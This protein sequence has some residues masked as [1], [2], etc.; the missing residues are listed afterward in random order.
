MKIN[1]K[2]LLS[3][4]I[5][6]EL[7]FN[8]FQSISVAAN[9]YSS[10]PYQGMFMQ[11]DIYIT[12]PLYTSW[13]PDAPDSI[14][15]A[16]KISK[17]YRGDYGTIVYDNS[18]EIGEIYKN[19]DN[20]YIDINGTK[21]DLKYNDGSVAISNSKFA[22]TYV[23]IS[24]SGADMDPTEVWL[25]FPNPDVSDNSAETNVTV[26]TNK[27]SEFLEKANNIKANEEKDASAW[28]TQSEMNIGSGEYREKWD[29]LLNE[30]Y[31]YLKTYLPAEKFEQ[32]KNEEN[33]W[34]NEKEK[35]VE[36]E[37]KEWE[38][39]SGR[40]LAMNAVDIDYTSE[41][42]YYLISLIASEDINDSITVTLN[43]EKLT[44]DAAPY[45]E[46]GTTMV[47]MRAIFEALGAVVD[48]DASTKS[49]TAHKGNTVIE[50]V[51]YSTAA[52][53]NGKTSALPIAVANKN[54]NTMIPLRF[55]SEALGAV[56]SF[57]NATKTVYINYDGSDIT[58]T[59]H[60]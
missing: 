4:L 29:V 57:D 34:I 27:K 58:D 22:G 2:I 30:V 21:A 14:G 12:M 26:Y 48:Y 35:A 42:V 11:N 51:T 31:S 19:G 7:L 43:G 44:F 60:K 49:I 47:P 9:D 6:T 20:Y 13:N 3:A 40:P 10:E 50:L 36:A 33:A 53:V 8:S 54:G 38:G 52:K 23:Q 24:N 46:N 17:P 45:V 41:R 16:Y 32:L 37:G 5:G 55:V 39:G 25:K 28:M 1:S 59:V 18:E 56:V 15:I